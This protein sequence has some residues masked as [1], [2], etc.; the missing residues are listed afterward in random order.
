MNRAVRT[1]RESLGEGAA[2]AG[3]GF[4]LVGTVLHPARDGAGVLEAGPLYGFT[5]SLQAVGLV[6]V[7]VA[8]ANLTIARVDTSGVS[9][10]G[11]LALIG[12]MWWL[13]L[14][15]YDGAHN[16]ATAAYAPELVH[17]PDGLEPG[18][19]LIVGPALILFPAGFIWLGRALARGGHGAS[20]WLMGGGALTYTIGGAMIFPLG[21][22][23]ALIQ[24]FEVLGVSAHTVGLVLMARRRA[25]P[26][27]AG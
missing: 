1:T 20:G 27:Q 9:G 10:A 11:N 2:L 22:E 25:V 24:A 5:H 13:A 16:P 14:I 12:T 15:V 4:F 8:I 19:G 6:F 18:A 7:G 3:A 17:S 26:R 21:P 23:S